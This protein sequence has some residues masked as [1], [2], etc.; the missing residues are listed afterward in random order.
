IRAD[1]GRDSLSDAGSSLTA[2]DLCLAE[3]RSVSEIP[4]AAGLPA[5]LAG[6]VGRTAVFGPR[7][8]FQADQARGAPRRRRRVPA[9]LIWRIRKVGR[10]KR[11]PRFSFRSREEV[12]YAALTHPMRLHLC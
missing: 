12:G 2:A 8:A 5:L 6:E 1:D 4:G 10:A 11:N 7:R 9:A 3:L